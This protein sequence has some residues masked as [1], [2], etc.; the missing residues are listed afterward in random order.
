MTVFLNGEFLPLAEAKISP[1]DRGFLFGD[2]VYEVIP[3]YAGKLFRGDEHLQRLQ[4]SLD[5]IRLK[6]PHTMEQWH[7]ILNQLIAH[8]PFDSQSIYLQVSRGTY[9]KREHSFPHTISPTVFIMSTELN[10]A[11]I[12]TQHEGVCTITRPDNR[13]QQ[14][15][16]KATTLLAN[17][18]LRQQATDHNCAETIL[19]RDGRVL[20]GAA[21]NV[22]IVKY[23]IIRTPA[24]NQQMLTG[25]TRDLILEIAAL[26]DIEADEESITLEQLLDADEVW[27]TSSTKEILP[28]I[29]VDD[30]I[31]GNG[32]PGLMWQTMINHYAEYKKKLVAG[33]IS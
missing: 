32:K 20:E 24:R 10:T 23:G 7:E 8:Q 31:I 28:V 25:I 14:C 29:R 19:F 17:I 27:I 18:L 1:L 22:F 33:E 15:D 2:G 16:I 3:V 12:S 11:E 26:H 6:N 4:S 30:T 21:S 13:W 9:S 5:G